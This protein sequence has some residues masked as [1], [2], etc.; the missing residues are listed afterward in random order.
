MISIQ[1]SGNY[2]QAVSGAFEHVEIE[3]AGGY[4]VTVADGSQLLMSEFGLLVLQPGSSPNQFIPWRSIS[5]IVEAKPAAAE[6]DD[7]QAH[8]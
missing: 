4:V 7:G 6:P 1:P 5:R 8:D 3:T 2:V